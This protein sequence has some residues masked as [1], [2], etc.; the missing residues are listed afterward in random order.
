[1]QFAYAQRAMVEKRTYLRTCVLLGKKEPAFALRASAGIKIRT[2]D[3][4][5]STRG[6]P[7]EA[8]SAQ[9]GCLFP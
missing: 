7:A 6:L 5:Y 2:P 9:A 3:T 4:C 1:M 8:R